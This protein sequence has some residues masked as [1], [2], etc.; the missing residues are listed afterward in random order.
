MKLFVLFGQ[1][2]CEY[3]GQ[4]AIEALACIDENGDSDNPDY[5]DA[6][7]AKYQASGEFDRLAVVPLSFSGEDIER[8]LYP[9]QQVIEAK[10]VSDEA[11]GD[12]G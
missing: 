1:R 3:P 5:L 4:Y 11:L 2:I 12:V 6:E 10:V 7:L 9:E 8:A